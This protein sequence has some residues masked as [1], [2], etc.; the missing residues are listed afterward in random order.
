MLTS[1]VRAIVTGGA[2]GLGRAVAAR[3]AAN[4]ANVVVADLPSSAGEKVA[5]EIGASFAPTDVTSTEQVNAALDLLKT[6]SGNEVNVVV[7]CAGILKPARVWHPKRGAHSLED[8]DAHLKVNVLGTFNVLRLA[9]E[10]MAVAEPSANGDRGVI[11]NT[12]SIAAFEGQLGQSAY[13]ASKGAIVGMT[14]PIARDLAK[15]GVRINVVCPGIFNTEMVAPLPETVKEQLAAAIPYP[16][17][18]GDPDEFA[19]L[20]EHIINNGYMNAEVIRLDGALRMT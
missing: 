13:S 15:S 5:A 6:V 19:A 18:L 14:M 1:A 9:V 7:N 20:V 12:A 16:A 4:G 11:V 10:R 8:F 17:R 3:L 2:S